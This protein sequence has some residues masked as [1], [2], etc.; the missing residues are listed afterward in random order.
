MITSLG[1]NAMR[2]TV[3]RAQAWCPSPMTRGGHARTS[4]CRK[5]ASTVWKAQASPRIYAHEICHEGHGSIPESSDR[6]G[7]VPW[8]RNAASTARTGRESPPIKDLGRHFR[9]KD[10]KYWVNIPTCRA[11]IPGLRWTHKVAC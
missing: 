10:S 3:L 7:L 9:S 11:V 5:L 4:W 1:F 8:L 6:S 2:M